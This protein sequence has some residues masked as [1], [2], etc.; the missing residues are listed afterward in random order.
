[1]SS[2]LTETQSLQSLIAGAAV[3]NPPQPTVLEVPV[4]IN[5]ARTVEGSDRREPFSEK[6]HTVLVFG[7]GAVI[8]LASAVSTGQL[9]FL[10]NEK[11]KKEVVCQVVKSKTQ[12][13]T[14]GYVELEFTES[15]PEFWGMRLAGAVPSNPAVRTSRAVEASA[16]PLLK[17]L[18]EKFAETKKP[19]VV[20]VAP[21]VPPPQAVV[22]ARPPVVER[23]VTPTVTPVG[24]TVEAH[25][26]I[27][28]A[29]SPAVS[30]APATPDSVPAQT[31]RIPTLS[32]FL[33]RGSDGAKLRPTPRL[34]SET[35][36]APSSTSHG[37]Q[38][39]Y[40]N[41]LTAALVASKNLNSAVAENA[42]PGSV[43]FD[44]A[45]GEEVKVPAWL[46]PLARNS[47]AAPPPPAEPRVT[48]AKPDE[49]AHSEAHPAKESETDLPPWLNAES[50]S[51]SAGSATEEKADG[52]LTLSGEGPVP[53]FGSGLAFDQNDKAAASRGSHTGLILTVV[54]VALLL[55][56]AGAWYWFS[57]QS[58]KAA[59]RESENA[60]QEYHPT[61]ATENSR[62][63]SNEPADRNASVPSDNAAVSAP[64]AANPA[65]KNFSNATVH[66]SLTTK[67]FGNAL[68]AGDAKPPS[69]SA[70]DASS[71]FAASPEP[72]AAK[73]PSVG[74]IHLAA[75]V[76]HHAKVSQDSAEPDPAL[77]AN[78][79]SAADANSL[80]LSSSKGPAAPTPVGG[81]VKPAHLISSV[82]PSFPAFARNQRISGNVV[83][84]ALVDANGNVSSM[85]VLSGPPMLH[86]AAMDA[87]RQW[88]YKPA[89]LNGQAV[90]MHLSVT[91][92]FKLQ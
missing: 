62:D 79:A 64:A 57:Q 33:A 22:E 9:L 69:N 46:E 36:D 75:P 16:A 54:A 43:T 80:G 87:L 66:D 41:G 14:A 38:A 6:T 12:P 83:I 77:S 82:A 53:N 7:N 81:D 26:K 74:Q 45:A 89:M 32:E 1:M 4:M 44:F 71:T 88:K 8:R 21:V 40:K 85:K 11:T 70:S 15:S 86:Q 67:P 84:D 31:V 50:K 23:E 10:T 60:A 30:A 90:P 3:E 20:P 37:S 63:S 73:K 35:N 51:G 42:A 91:L 56:A 52:I 47:A 48:E 49:S 17:S 39:A 92:Q 27:P 13:A 18:E 72:S 59:N 61:F 2:N 76:V 5:G 78:P 58:T 55:I 68:S 29:E 25:A 34:A 28:P 19:P 24:A 65:A